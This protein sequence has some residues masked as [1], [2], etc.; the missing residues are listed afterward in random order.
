MVVVV[1]D[2]IVQEL[3]VEMQVLLVIMVV[4]VETKVTTLEDLVEL[5]AVVMEVL[6]LVN[7]RE[8]LVK[9]LLGLSGV[10]ADH[11]QIMRHKL[12]GN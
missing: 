10:W 9:V 11:S 4:L 7:L 8:I 5:M 6:N 3:K 1:K 2:K 12:R